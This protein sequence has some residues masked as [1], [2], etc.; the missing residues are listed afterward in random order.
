MSYV[1]VLSIELF[2]LDIFFQVKRI[3]YVGSYMPVCYLLQHLNLWTDFRKFNL[4]QFQILPMLTPDG[5]FLRP[6][7][8][9]QAIGKFN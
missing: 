2:I 3:L 1:Y 8:H 6:Y 9:K 4:R 7:M 5:I